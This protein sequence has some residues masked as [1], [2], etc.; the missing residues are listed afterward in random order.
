MQSRKCIDK[1]LHGVGS[2]NIDCKD[3]AGHIGGSGGF[4][5]SERGRP[6]ILG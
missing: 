4:R 3:N 2:D 1:I 6:Q 5:N